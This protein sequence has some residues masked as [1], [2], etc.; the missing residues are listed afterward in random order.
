MRFSKIPTVAW[1]CITA[2]FLGTVAAFAWLSSIGA[3]G[4]EF[5]S[6]LNT[7]MNLG[8]LLLGGGA[9]AYAGQAAA[10]TNGDLDK[11]IKDAVTAALDRQREE[12]TGAV[13]PFR[14]GGVIR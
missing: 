11:R 12:D 5:R 13:A 8:G 4:S 10:Q 9:V 14:E 2:A 3:D 1:L 6:F 7:V